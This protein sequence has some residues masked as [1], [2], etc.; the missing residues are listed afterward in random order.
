MA[1]LRFA[2]DGSSSNTVSRFPLALALV[3]FLLF[4]WEP[5]LHNRPPP[6]PRSFRP[7]STK[8]RADWEAN[9]ASK[10]SPT[11]SDNNWP[12]SSSAICSLC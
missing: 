12:N 1:L 4:G 8:S 7:E 3:I 11:K 9:R 10:M 2:H 5:L 6:T